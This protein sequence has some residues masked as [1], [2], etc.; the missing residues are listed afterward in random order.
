MTGLAVIIVNY[1]VRELL[2]ECLRSLSESETPRALEVFVVDNASADGSS[3]MVRSDF[4]W[5]KL[6]ESPN[7]G[8]AHANNLVMREILRRA[9]TAPQAGLP[10]IL[11]L[12]PDTYLPPHALE[13]MAVFLEEH[14]RAGVVGPRLMRPNGRLDLA[15]RRS[16]PTP[17]VSMYRMLGLSKL[18][19][20]R[21]R[22]ARY[23]LT[24]LDPSEVA[25]V[26][27][28]V[29]AFMLI[30][31]EALQQAGVFDESFFMYGEDLDLAFR[32]KRCGWSVLYNGQVEVLHHK[33]E[34]SRQAKTKA[35]TEFYRAMLLFYR[36]HYASSTRFPLSWLVVGG[37]Y[38]RGGLALVESQALKMLQ[39]GTKE[40]RQSAS[41]FAEGAR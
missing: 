17:E 16:F 41:S 15:C 33:G 3:A 19:P 2:R 22:F 21:R 28:V 4:P 34:S 32:I 26:D 36:K 9:Q 39:N 38:L 23:N 25:E 37:I 31:S 24:Y 5:V 40:S 1:N 35:V 10:H 12:N 8:Y 7:N 29:G 13:Q 27:S 14:P 30:R 11:L 18:F 20:K 6:I